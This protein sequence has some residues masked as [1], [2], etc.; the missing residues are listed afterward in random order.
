MMKPFYL[1]NN[2]NIVFPKREIYANQ[3]LELWFRDEGIPSVGVIKGYFHDD[4]ISV[5]V[6]D[7]E[8]PPLHPS[9]IMDWF[10]TYKN[11][12]YVEIGANRVQTSYI[13]K[14]VVFRGGQLNLSETL[15]TATEVGDDEEEGEEKGD[16]KGKTLIEE[17]TE[18]DKK[19]KIGF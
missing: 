5:F 17:A 16:E 19:E 11:L 15:A 10:N 13:P 4:H 1:D 9:A 8:I 12:A 6:N 7:F 3:T 14:L 2:L 18:I